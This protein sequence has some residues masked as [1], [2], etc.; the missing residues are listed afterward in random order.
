MHNL[1]NIVIIVSDCSLY[2]LQYHISAIFINLPLYF[3]DDE[4]DVCG[5]IAS[6]CLCFNC[7]ESRIFEHLSTNIVQPEDTP[8]LYLQHFLASVIQSK[9]W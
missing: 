4:N 9:A 5:I 6:L 8:P 1:K 7:F 3:Y 2:D